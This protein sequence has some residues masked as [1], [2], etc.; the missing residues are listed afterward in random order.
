MGMTS[1]HTSDFG[2]SDAKP[3]SAKDRAIALSAVQPHDSVLL[4][5]M[6]EL[7]VGRSAGHWRIGT[8]HEAD[9]LMFGPQADEALLARWRLSGK[10]W[11]ALQDPE[12]EPTTASHVL[13]RPLRVFPLLALLKE[14]EEEA[15]ETAPSPGVAH[16]QPLPS[17]WQL[18]DALRTLG[19]GTTHGQWLRTGGI[20]VR[21]DGRQFAAADADL[22]RIREGRLQDAGFT[23]RVPA[24][25]AG[26]RV[27][28]IEELAWFAGWWADGERLA[29][30]LSADMR[31]RIRH[32][33]D[34]GTI[35]AGRD[36]IRL[37]AMLGNQMWTADELV[38]ASG[39][40]RSQVVRYLN[41]TSVSGLLVTRAGAPRVQP[42]RPPG[43]IASLVR[44][45]RARLGLG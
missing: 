25:P 38:A 18:A 43:L 4:A 35:R 32:W 12:D 40:D 44:G 23:D 27:H 21:D 36:A 41:A 6:L 33:P 22:A 15:G 5:S 26:L 29:P 20:Y 39:I 16:P 17:N 28:P 9:V 1:R 3:E 30:W 42:E 7:L 19:M 10:P 14:I 13:H 2:H 34:L 45:L 24:P 37:T 11:V 31:F 8:L